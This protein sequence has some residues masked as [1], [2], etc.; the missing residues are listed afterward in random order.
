VQNILIAGDVYHGNCGVNIQGA[1]DITLEHV[2]TE[3]ISNGVCTPV[4]TGGVIQTLFINDSLFDEGVYGINVSPAS[5]GAVQLIKLHH[6]WVATNM[7]SG[8]FLNA[9]SGAVIQEVDLDDDTVANN[10]A[11]GLLN[12]SAANTNIRVR[13]GCYANNA[14]NG[15]TEAGS[16]TLFQIADATTGP[17]GEFPGNAGY[18]ISLAGSNTNFDIHDLNAIGN[19]MGALQLVGYGGTTGVIHDVQGYN[20]VGVTGPTA[21]PASPATLC[22]GPSPQTMYFLQAA[23]NT[24]TIQLGGAS[25]PVVGTM[26]SAIAP[27]TIG[28]GSN[29]CV[30]VTWSTTD[31]TYTVS[32]H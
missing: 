2:S 31:P 22:A 11:H 20:P 5:S 23:T 17:C 19:T 9:A 13:G 16:T 21:V 1:G 14:L 4:P 18:G 25:G 12:E 28:L 26:A 6:S 27:V 24:A 30:Y 10:G 8:I 29:E 3:Q 32:I 15:I 7:A